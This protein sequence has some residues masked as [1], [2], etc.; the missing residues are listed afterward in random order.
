MTLEVTNS[1]RFHKLPP[2][3]TA[4][5]QNPLRQNV[6]R[7]QA[8]GKHPKGKFEDGTQDLHHNTLVAKRN[9]TSP[10]LYNLS[11]PPN[12]FVADA[13]RPRESRHTTQQPRLPRLQLAAQRTGPAPRTT[14]MTH[15]RINSLDQLSKSNPNRHTLVEEHLVVGEDSLFV[16]LASVVRL[17]LACRVSDGPLEEFVLSNS[18]QTQNNLRRTSSCVTGQKSH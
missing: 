10:H 13:L 8:F 15:D 16:T 6:L 4:P 2:A 1:S 12:P 3:F 17:N 9:K 7:G 11:G 14:T 5:R 18:S